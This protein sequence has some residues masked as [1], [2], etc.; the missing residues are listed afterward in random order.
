MS[1]KHKNHQ[2][3]PS[4]A[5]G[6]KAPG[7]QHPCPVCGGVL[8][9]ARWSDIGTEFGC[10]QCGNW[11]HSDVIRDGA[12]RS[13]PG[14]SQNG[15]RFS[16]SSILLPIKSVTLREAVDELVPKALHGTGD[17]FLHS[18][19]IAESLKK[20]LDL[21]SVEYHHGLAFL[22]HRL[23]ESSGHRMALGI[24]PNGLQGEGGSESR[25]FVVALFLRSTREPGYDIPLWARRSMCND[26]M[27]YQ[28]R[29]A[30][31][32]PAVL[33]VFAAPAGPGA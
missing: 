9:L 11:F 27:I 25:I 15:A 2:A 29:T 4:P 21:Q 28:L 3:A 13:S 22:H 26:K 1:A 8:G 23:R 17:V 33:K 7:E 12:D 6:S 14:E 31:D 20:G 19:K 32:I 30:P 24:S 18:A 16:P 10:G 5:S